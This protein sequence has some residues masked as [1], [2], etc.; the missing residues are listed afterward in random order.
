M[1]RFFIEIAYNGT[2]YHGWQ[3][4]QNANTVQAEINKAISTLLNEKITVIGAGRTDTGVHAQQLFAHFDTSIP[5]E[6]E[7]LLFKLNSFL[8][9]DIACNSIFKVN[10]DA[11]ARFS[12][13]TRTYEYWI[14]PTKT[15][16]LINKAYY[17]PHSLNIDLMNKAAKELMLHT[18][19]SCFSKSK[20]DTFTNDCNITSASWKTIDNQLV[21]TI[22]AN[23]FLRNMVRAI[24]GTLLEIGQNKITIED[25][26]K[27]IKS[28]NRSEAGQ[29]VPAHGLFL[30][31]VE[32]PELSDDL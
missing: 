3:I 4:Q 32:Y 25:L 31:K 8:P 30:V 29:S 27:I 17:F 26:K 16:F 28:K 7:K 1:S 21:F 22:S 9:D 24:V 13:T 5:F 23:R 12:A 6:T 18:D 10:S 14:T 19:F 20:T 2:N 11:H 15:P